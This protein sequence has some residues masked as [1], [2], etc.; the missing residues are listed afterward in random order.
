VQDAQAGGPVGLVRR[1][2]VEVGVDVLEVH[3]QLRHRLRPV[4]ERDRAGRVGAAH[5]VGDRRDRPHDVGDVR[6]GHELHAAGGQQRVEHVQVEH[7]LVVQ[8]H[9]GQFGPGRL[10]EDLPR[11]D[12]AVVLQ[13]GEDDEIPG[14]DVRA[15]PGVRD[16]VDRLG[17]VLG[18]HRLLDSRTQPGRDRRASALEGVRGLHRQRVHPAMHVGVVVGVMLGDRV[19]HRLRLLRR[20]PRVEVH[21]LLAVHL[22]LQQGELRLDC[23]RV[24]SLWVEG[25]HRCNHR[26]AHRNASYPSCSSWAA[27]SMPPLATMRPLIM[28]CT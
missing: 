20:G 1:P 15:T 22:A 3:R 2:H 5:D 16:E 17:G 12:V 11:H 28:M 21:E 8:G 10:G 14:S 7:A 19:D 23:G 6:A 13:V 9:V 24:E 18:E 25:V 27:S 26:S 4:D